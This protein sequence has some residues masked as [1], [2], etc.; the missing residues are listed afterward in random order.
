MNPHMNQIY[1][2]IIEGHLNSFDKNAQDVA[3]TPTPAAD[4]F[5]QFYPPSF[6]EWQKT[7][8]PESMSKVLNFYDRLIS[9]EASKYSGVIPTDAAKS[10]AKKFAIQAIKKYDPSRPAKLSTWITNYLKQLNRIK[11]SMQQ[12]TRMPENLQMM[13]GHY[14]EAL[15]ELK[16]ELGRDPTNVEIAEKINRPVSLIEKLNKQIYSE[17]QE[18]RLEYDPKAIESS[19]PRIDY[20]YYDLDPQ[21]KYIFEHT[22]G[23]GAKPKLSKKEIAERLGI[24]PASVSMRGKKIAE[25]LEEILSEGKFG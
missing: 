5:G 2:Y 22:T 17:L 9:S 11:Y 18:G 3:S 15:E 10:Y 12:A 19:D 24:S 23:Y 20:V 14:K 25:K 7:Q 6:E 13:V 8:S 1:E 4:A 21:E 16:Q